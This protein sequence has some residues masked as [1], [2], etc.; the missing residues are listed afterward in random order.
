M[1]ANT[2]CFRISVSIIARGACFF[3][4]LSPIIYVKLNPTFFSPWIFSLFLRKRRLQTIFWRPSFLQKLFS[5][6]IF[7]RRTFFPS[8]NEPLAFEALPEAYAALQSPLF[9]SPA[10]DFPVFL[11][12]QPA[13]TPP[14]TIRGIILR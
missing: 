5:L 12:P 4:R 8:R 10:R 13:P 1:P 9:L 2:S 3:K 14:P 11:S 7:L 6:L